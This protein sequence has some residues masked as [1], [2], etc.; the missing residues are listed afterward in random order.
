MNNVNIY[1]HTDLGDALAN[2]EELIDDLPF[3]Y[4]GL[5]LLKHY[6]RDKIYE[7]DKQLMGDYAF[8]LTPNFPNHYVYSVYIQDGNIGVHHLL[9]DT[10]RGWTANIKDSIKNSISKTM[11]DYVNRNYPKPF[12]E[13]ERHKKYLLDKWDNTSYI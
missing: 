6:K 4:K 10:D 12:S 3:R 13:K 5:I 1:L 11:C 8:G 7:E 2:C 9:F